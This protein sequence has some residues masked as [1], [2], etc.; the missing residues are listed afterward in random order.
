MQE[1]D[2]INFLAGK[3]GPEFGMPSST[4]RVDVSAAMTWLPILRQMA[5]APGSSGAFASSLIQQARKMRQY[6][7]QPAAVVDLYAADDGIEGMLDAGV[8]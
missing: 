6:G 8:R 2:A 3:Q 7:S 1:P 4:R 5:A